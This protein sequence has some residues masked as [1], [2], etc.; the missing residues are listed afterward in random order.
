MSEETAAEPE[1]ASTSAPSE[2][3]T[4][5]AAP[6]SWLND[7]SPDYRSNP[8]I[9]KFTSTNE[10]A[11]GY[12]NAESAI[13]SEKISTPRE[14]WTEDN[15]NEFHTKLGR[16]IS[17][18]DYD[19]GDFVAPESGWSEEY[20]SELI[21]V[22]HECG[23][24]SELVEAVLSTQAKFQ[25]GDHETR[26]QEAVQ[27]TDQNVQQL[28][29]EM[30]A[31]FDAQVDGAHQA[32]KQFAGDDFETLAN[33]ELA[34][35][36][37]IGNNPALIRIFAAISDGMS[38]HGLVGSDTSSRTTLSPGEAG[39]EIMR[40]KGDEGFRK[41]WLDKAHPEHDMAVQHIDSLTRMEM[42]NEE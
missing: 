40:V 24:N 29:N 12:I 14:D 11:R 26:F 30:G 23:A 15:W 19:L 5:S 7:L 6:A 1:G 16:P 13:G 36:T 31:S 28:R 27:L 17:A 37:I 33:T 22:M 21:D 42:S 41:A 2:A 39:R 35:G 4:T 3:T 18:A 34:D 8:S 25:T 20:Q 10:L 9:T 38:E 32:W